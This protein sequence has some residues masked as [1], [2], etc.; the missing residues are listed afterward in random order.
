MKSPI[1]KYTPPP[2]LEKKPDSKEGKESKAASGDV[3]AGGSPA[4]NPA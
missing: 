2:V 1:S 3:A 4:P